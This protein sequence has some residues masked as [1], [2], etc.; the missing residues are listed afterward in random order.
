MQTS[1]GRALGAA[2]RV[3]VFPF[4][5]TQAA[6]RV[7]LSHPRAGCALR[8]A[9]QNSRGKASLA[10]PSPRRYAAPSKP[11]LPVKGEACPTPKHG[12]RT[13]SLGTFAPYQF[14][15]RPFPLQT[16]SSFVASSHFAS[17]VTPP[18]ATPRAPTSRGASSLSE[19]SSAPNASSAETPKKATVPETETAAA[20][21]KP[22]SDGIPPSAFRLRAAESDSPRR[23][24]GGTGPNDEF[25]PPPP[26]RGFLLLFATLTALSGVAI[27]LILYDAAVG[28]AALLYG[29]WKFDWDAPWL[30]AAAQREAQLAAQGVQTHSPAAV[31]AAEAGAHVRPPTRQIILVRHGQY[32]NVASTSDEEQGLTELGKIQAAVTGRRLKELLKDQ[33]VVAIW[34][35]DMK[36]ARE[37]AQI[38]HKEAFSDV[39]LLQDPLLAEG[40]PAEPVPPSRTFKPT[41]EEIM[42]DSARIE[43][44]FRRYFYRA[45]PPASTAANAAAGAAS[46]S[47]EAEKQAGVAA[48]GNVGNDSY[49]IIVCHGNVI[50]YMLMRALQ[51]PGCAWLRWATYN[52][53]ISWISIDS[54]GYVSCREFG[55]VGHLPAD[56][57]TYH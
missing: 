4:Q 48:E 20:Q 30:D 33:H 54:K 34:H 57:I 11:F 56:M 50:R 35:S 19:G 3:F 16:L 29:A 26:G 53:G 32:A 18:S 41:A 24:V 55:D 5:R 49:I 8:C 7:S 10:S 6:E 31:R 37:T 2:L 27:G 36:R 23:D 22:V 46:P 40:V 44:A 47:A 1:N 45:L 28:E 9:W 13:A 52:T 38:I 43:E 42:V 17:E 21:E 12:G 39:P 25:P 15:V 14:G 51:L